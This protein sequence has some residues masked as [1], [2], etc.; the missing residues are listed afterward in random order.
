MQSQQSESKVE[1]DYQIR[2]LHKDITILKQ[3][4]D[5]EFQTMRREIEELNYTKNKYSLENYNLEVKLHDFVDKFEEIKKANQSLVLELNDVKN[6]NNRTEF[7]I[8]TLK[9]EAERPFRENKQL[10]NDLEDILKKVNE[11]QEM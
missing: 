2:S 3:L 6:K 11:K 4:Y 5:D 10:R 7:E 1:K 9:L 8:Q